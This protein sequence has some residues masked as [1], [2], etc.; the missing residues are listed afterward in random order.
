MSGLSLAGRLCGA[1]A[2]A[3]AAMALGAAAAAAVEPHPTVGR[4]PGFPRARGVVPVLDSPAAVSARERLIK[5][6]FGAA[7]AKGPALE[8]AQARQ[9]CPPEFVNTQDVCYLGGPVLRKPV[10]HLIFWQGPPTLNVE[11]FP[12]HYIETIEQYF[13]D[14]QAASGLPSDVYAVDPQYGES[15]QPGVLSGVDGS[16]FSRAIDAAIDPTRSF[17]NE[18]TDT[19]AS[20][21]GPCVSDAGIQK[22][23]TEVAAEVA[24]KWP[25]NLE[26]LFFV[27]T[28]RG[29]GSCAVFGCAYQAYC[30]Y[31]G[32]FGGNGVTPGPQTVYA[33]MPFAVPGVC[34]VGVHPNEAE[35]LGTDGA[36][37]TTSHEFNESIT[38][39][40]GSQ[41]KNVAKEECEPSSW[42]DAIGQEIGDK[43]LPPETTVAGTYGEPLVQ[44][45]TSMS[46][47][48]LINGHPYWTQTE[49]SNEA[50]E[51]N[52]QC[53]QRFVN[54]AFSPPSGARATVPTSFDGSAS[55][56]GAADPIVYWVWDFGDQ[57]QVGTPE[58]TVSH[59]YATSGARTV[60]LTAFDKYGNSNTHT[61]AV[62][63]GAPPPPPP[64]PVL[65]PV[66]TKT[67]TEV[68]P[69]PPILHFTA[70]QVAE[71]LGLPGNGKT[72]AGLG[73]IALGH[74]ECPPACQVTLNL[75]ASIRTAKGHKTTVKQVLIGTLTTTIAPKG[76]GALALRLNAAGR[77]LLS[78][79]HKL[80]SRLTVAVVG[81]E[82]G[83]WQIVRSLTLTSTGRAAGHA[84]R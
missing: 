71:K 20:S 72:L 7:R 59:T 10:V 32:D 18:C 84:R 38:D 77:R 60:T 46:Y 82:G 31:H 16:S 75:Y 67:V 24:H 56:E 57:L 55:G 43:C 29:V 2:C 33:N 1:L 13:E 66:V 80:S 63:V 51:R 42:I 73:T 39:P 27:F 37:D 19:T 6:A 35:D 74:A 34:G 81:E 11:S 36:I 23:I 52:G 70:D 47:N 45:L 48:Q 25:S 17:V 58:P 64:S 79:S 83:T 54:A 8:P 26:N 61:L 49:W 69:A 22:E 14:V 41:C 4:L 28:P 40:L 9:S 68:A 12:A 21:K 44:P 76:T 62:E 53:V 50:G 3:V 78:K 65:P 5:E 15:E 30:A